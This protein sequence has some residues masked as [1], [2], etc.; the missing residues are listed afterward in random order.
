[1]PLPVIADVYR[2][3]VTLL[4][5]D[6]TTATNVFH[7]GSGA[8]SETALA[9]SID[10]LRGGVTPW[11]FASDVYDRSKISIEKLDGVSAAFERNCVNI[12]GT[13]SGQILY[14]AAAVIKLTTAVRGRSARGRMYIGPLT[15]ATVAGG[16]VNGGTVTALD[17]AFE[18]WVTGVEGD[19]GGN[20]K[21]VSY[22]HSTA[23]N[24]TGHLTETQQRTQRRRLRRKTG[25]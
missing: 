12:K 14:E 2:C 5:V 6:G 10:T 8:T 7:F 18:D 1:M 20:F 11:D 17:T 23:Q 16:V 19:I 21:I 9:D 22:L 13:Q 15:E 4:G 25:P 3:A 24:L